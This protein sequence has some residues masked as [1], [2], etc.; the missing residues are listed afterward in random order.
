MSE[1]IQID[2]VVLEHSRALPLETSGRIK[3]MEKL[4]AHREGKLHLAVS[5]FIFDSQGR[6]LLQQRAPDKYHSPGK[7]SNTCCT[8]P[9][10]GESPLHAAGRRLMEEMGMQSD[11]KEVFTLVYRVDVGE[12]LIE[13]EFVHVY[14]GSKDA[15]P[16]PSATEVSAWKWMAEADLETDIQV[17]PTDYTPWFKLIRAEWKKQ[18][19]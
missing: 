8:H 1:Q 5:V 17:H 19:K 7:W 16:R 18:I 10:P 12:I 2:P 6:L 15:D 3:T 14:L 13:H 11:L 4:A 9:K